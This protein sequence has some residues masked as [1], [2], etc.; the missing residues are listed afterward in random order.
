MQRR[1]PCSNRFR[2]AAPSQPVQ[3]ALRAALWKESTVTFFPS[4]LLFAVLNFVFY[5]FMG[6]IRK[7]FEWLHMSLMCYMQDFTSIGKWPSS[8]IEEPRKENSL[9]VN[10]GGNKI[11]QPDYCGIDN[12]IW[13]LLMMNMF[14]MYVYVIFTFN[15]WIL[16]SHKTKEIL[17]FVTTWM[18]LDT[19]QVEW[20]RNSK[21]LH[22][23]TYMSNLNISNIYGEQDGGYWV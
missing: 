4:S 8:T 17:L 19:C 3:G 22:D 6:R 2:S 11:R 15:I 7:R 23:C 12:F 20:V 14:A 16:F 10:K 21:I 9:Y 1:M 18:N 13:A 5:E